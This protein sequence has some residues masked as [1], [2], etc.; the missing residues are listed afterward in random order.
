MVF[1]IMEN[2]LNITPENDFRKGNKKNITIINATKIY[3]HMKRL[4]LFFIMYTS[5][6]N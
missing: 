4:K 2:G 3:M 6:G 1:K 5:I